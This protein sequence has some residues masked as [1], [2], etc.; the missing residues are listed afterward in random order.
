MDALEY[1]IIKTLQL[2]ILVHI[3][4]RKWRLWC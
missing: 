2:T 3:W 4:E 1:K